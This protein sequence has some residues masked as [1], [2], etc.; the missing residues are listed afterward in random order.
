VDKC[1]AVTLSNCES[2]IN[3]N[4]CFACED[5]FYLSS[6]RCF[7]VDTI[8]NCSKNKNKDHC[9]LCNEGYALSTGNKLI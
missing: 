5:G 9:E 2:Y 3:K 6:G 1:E 8:A 7:E 4:E